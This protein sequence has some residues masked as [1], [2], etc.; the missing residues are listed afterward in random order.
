MNVL[1]LFS[2]VGFGELYFSKYNF[3]VV[4]ANELLRDRADFYAKLHPNTNQVVCGDI[5]DAKIKD[6][7]VHAC[8][9]FGPIDMV[10]ATPPCQG[11]S[12]ANATKK[13]N[14]IRNTL[15]VHA[16]E[17][18]NR[19]GAKYML[20]ENVPQMGK[21]YINYENN[22]VNIIDYIQSQTPKNY[23]CNYNV[24]NA[25][26]YGSPQSRSRSICLI[27]EQGKW[28][29]P[30]PYK[31]CKTV[32]DAI[33][34]L[35]KFPSL[36]NG[37]HSDIKWHFSKKH[38]P[39]HIIWMTNTPTGNTAFNNKIHYPKV[40]ENGVIRKIK[41]FKTTYK[42]MHW[43]KPAPTVTMTNGSI[44]SQNNVHP[45]LQNID[46]TY[47]DARV[48]SIREILAICGLPITLFDSKDFVIKKNRKNAILYEY[49]YSET[50]IRNI[51][52]EIFLPKMAEALI[53]NI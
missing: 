52:G 36:S 17:I 7:I 24:L 40:T 10:M 23:I 21:T 48:L 6:D 5:R 13:S 28:K 43:D 29:H 20:I 46:G 12:I 11:M 51:L 9:K 2:N 3:N 19:V 47:S 41:G 31:K 45:G 34:N 35:Q 16:M 37:E 30:K 42:R 22:V 26:D 53:K 18:F 4:V 32:R 1:S 33:G 14:D 38:N 44:S 25:K 39:H 27:S 8:D 15:I 49:K 50:F